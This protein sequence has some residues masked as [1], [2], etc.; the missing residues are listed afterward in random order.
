VKKTERDSGLTLGERFAAAFFGALW[1]LAIGGLLYGAIF[2]RSV[3]GLAPPTVV[4]IPVAYSAAFGFIFG[5]ALGDVMS[6]FFVLFF[7]RSAWDRDPDNR[8]GSPVRPFVMFFV[9]A[10]PLVL[11]MRWLIK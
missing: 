8:V 11:L 10:L 4:W 5:D 2:L 9:Y 3:G 6:V 1:G 7:R